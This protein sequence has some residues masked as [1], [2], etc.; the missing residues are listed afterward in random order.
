M[1]TVKMV[2]AALFE[3]IVRLLGLRLGS[4]AGGEKKVKDD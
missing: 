3:G 2:L 4:V 1:Q